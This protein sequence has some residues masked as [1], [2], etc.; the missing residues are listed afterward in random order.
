M[1][2]V[3]T[4]VTLKLDNGNSVDLLLTAGE[5]G[6]S[7]RSGEEYGWFLVTF[8]KDGTLERHSSIDEPELFQLTPKQR[9]KA[10]K[11]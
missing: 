3:S 2:L 8:R 1:A 7:V 4:K 6:V 10:V 11:D 9:I 5:D